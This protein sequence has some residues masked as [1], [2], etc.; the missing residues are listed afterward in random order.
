MFLCGYFLKML[1]QK[2]WD[3]LSRFDSPFLKVVESGIHPHL[4][5]SNTHSRHSS[6][7]AQSVKPPV[8]PVAG[9]IATG[10]SFFRSII[11]I[12]YS[13]SSHCQPHPPLPLFHLHR[14]LP[15]GNQLNLLAKQERV[16]QFTES[17]VEFTASQ[18]E[19]RHWLVE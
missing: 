19:D 11:L 18:R 1:L 3:A 5:H 2:R 10:K 14:Y 9:T 12:L 6:H 15:L 17:P 13:Q 16:Q 8:G 7:Q 4:R